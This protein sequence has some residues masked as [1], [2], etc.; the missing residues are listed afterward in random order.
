[1]KNSNHQT[2]LPIILLYFTVLIISPIFHLHAGE[3]HFDLHSDIFHSHDMPFEMANHEHD[4]D[5]VPPTE[6]LQ[7][8]QVTPRIQRVLTA[9]LNTQLSTDFQHFFVSTFLLPLSVCNYP[10]SVKQFPPNI[11]SPQWDNYILFGANTSPP[12][13][14]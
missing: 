6:N 12:A 3:Y 14:A 2:T 11:L 10:I 5:E 1:M 8:Q 9:D 13:L 7:L 4:E